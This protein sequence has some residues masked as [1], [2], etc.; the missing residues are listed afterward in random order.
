M[1]EKTRPNIASISSA[2]EL[3]RWYWL[4]DELIEQARNVGVK[5]SG[6]K[7]IILDRLAYF[8]DTGKIVWPGD[9]KP[10]IGS[11]FNWHTEPLSLQTLIT[12]SYKNS[13]N[14]RRF[15]KQ[16][17]GDKFKFNIALMD[18]MK[19]AQGKTLADAVK[20]Y[21]RLTSLSADAGFQSKIKPHNQFNQYTRDILLANSGMSASEARRIWEKKRALPSETGR[22]IYE[23]SD[24]D[25]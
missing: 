7:F 15:F 11:K 22:H 12:D 4:K 23:P 14:V 10:K 21:G 20:E 3:K 24:L 13:Q 25:L 2:E 18:W 5:A 16:H 19:S 17:A 1:T 9:E 8:L 6:G